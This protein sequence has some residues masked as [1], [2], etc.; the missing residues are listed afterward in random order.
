MPTEF[1]FGDDGKVRFN[2]TWGVFLQD[3]D[4]S[5]LNHEAAREM[6]N[7]DFPDWANAMVGPG[8][9]TVWPL[10]RGTA[11]GKA[12]TVPDLLRL[13]R[14]VRKHYVDPAQHHQQFQ[15]Q[16]PNQ[17]AQAQPNPPPNHDPL[18]KSSVPWSKEDVLL[19]KSCLPAMPA[20][21]TYQWEK[22]LLSLCDVVESLINSPHPPSAQIVE[23]QKLMRDEY[24]KVAWKDAEQLKQQKVIHHLL[25]FEHI[26]AR[27]FAQYKSGDQARGN[28]GTRNQRPVTGSFERPTPQVK[29]PCRFCSRWHLDFHCP[30]RRQGNQQQGQQHGLSQGS[31]NF[32]GQSWGRRWR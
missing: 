10:I 19:F 30:Q 13:D 15:Q 1:D 21:C 24:A 28:E 2:D 6:A 31:P 22:R 9:S 17:Q 29:R 26:K 5:R 12:F 3:F 8:H 25:D 18:L 14:V 11:G 7:H 32:Q 23:L 27:P 20:L 16:Q 4:P